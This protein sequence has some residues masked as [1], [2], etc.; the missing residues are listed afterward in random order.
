MAWSETQSTLNGVPDLFR[1]AVSAVDAGDIGEL[2][3]YLRD[4]QRRE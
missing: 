3:P 1:A 4:R 2:E